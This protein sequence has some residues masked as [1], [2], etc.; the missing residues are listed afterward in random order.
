MNTMDIDSA[1]EALGSLDAALD[2]VNSYRADFGATQN[3]LSSTSNGLGNDIQ[4][5]SAANSR[6][7]DTDIAEKS[8]ELVKQNI[9]NTASIAVLSQA[10]QLPTQ[11]LKLL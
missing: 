1:R 9:L 3:R 10:N 2:K 11:A 7:R 8:A 6:I 5:L 4:G